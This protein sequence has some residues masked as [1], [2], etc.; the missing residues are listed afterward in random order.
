MKHKILEVEWIDSEAH[1]GW[2]ENSKALAYAK[3]HELLCY[4]VG[5]FLH[6]DTEVLT[7]AMSYND[8]EK[9]ML[10]KIPKVNI[11]KRKVLK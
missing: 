2:H 6:E 8:E 7:I 9:G 4:T 1:P 3:K 11:I 10:W 5:Y